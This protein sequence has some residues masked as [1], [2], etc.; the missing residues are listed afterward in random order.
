M[1]AVGPAPDPVRGEPACAYV[2]PK[3]G[4][5]PSEEELISFAG[6]RLASC[7]RPHMARF[8]DDLP[9]T[10]TARSCAER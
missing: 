7:K 1:V 3:A 5:S 4:S 8:V 9:E 6:L 10:A 2:I